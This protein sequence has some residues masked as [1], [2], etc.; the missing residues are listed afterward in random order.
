MINFIKKYFDLIG[1]IA[2]AIFFV[3]LNYNLYI[4]MDLL[5]DSDMASEM[6]YAKLLLE[7]KTLISSNWYFSTTIETLNI[8]LVF[9]PLFLLTNNWHT[10]RIAGIIILDIFLYL[11]FY[12][13]C[14]QLEIKHIPWLAFLILGSISYDYFYYV[15]RGSYYIPYILTTFLSIGLIIDISKNKKIFS[16]KTILL[17]II[18][19]LSGLSGIRQ[20]AQCYVCLFG[21]SILVFIIKQYRCILYKIISRKDDSY[22]LIITSTISLL[23]SIVGY[24]INKV[25]LEAKYSFSPV[26]KLNFK[27]ASLNKILDI[28]YDWATLF[29]YQTGNIV[30]TGIAIILIILTIYSCLYI[31][32]K[33]NDIYDLW[34]V[35]LY[36]CISIVTL[37]IFLF[38]DM[39]L[40]TR[41]FLLS[42]SCLPFVIGIYLRKKNTISYASSF[43]IL[44]VSIILTISNYKFCIDGTNN[45]DL[46]EIKDKLI[47]QECYNGYG[48]F[49]YANVFTELSDGKI[50]AWSYKSKVKGEENVDVDNLYKWLQKKKHFIEYP[51]GR[52]FLVLS[53]VE[54][55]KVNFVIDVSQNTYYIGDKATLY[56][57]NS[58]IELF[59]ALNIK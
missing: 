12:Y 32:K 3:V 16:Y 57:F 1:Y 30:R 29:G 43:V 17:I 13:A 27:I 24:L 52:V 10:V 41:Y 26:F 44:V 15:L 39:L 18:S 33:A 53:N 23:M 6:I 37:C 5:V 59:E 45:K 49:W 36:A 28:G 34:I 47:E 8:P 14:K 4:N 51:N 2:L 19:M 40:A 11:S 48:S 21:A 7:E 25:F 54:Q 56:I 38:T 31:F 46:I 20:V 42:L 9:A 35:I 55:K 50:E 58:Y 22:R